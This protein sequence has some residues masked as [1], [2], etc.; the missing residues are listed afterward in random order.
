VYYGQ[1]AGNKQFG[2]F[3]HRGEAITSE[4]ALAAEIMSRFCIDLPSVGR[5]LRSGAWAFLGRYTLRQELKREPVLVQ[6]PVGTT[7]ATLWEGPKQL[8]NVAVWEPSIQNL[9]VI[10]AYDAEYHVPQRLRADFEQPAD[11][12]RVG[13]SVLHNRLQRQD[14]AS[15]FP[16][17]HQLPED[18]VWAQ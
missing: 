13:G 7:T 16:N 5:A 15:R 4:A 8:T 9:E 1:I 14:L 18:W 17:Q 12:W 11:A 6:W 2:A 3:R 10:A